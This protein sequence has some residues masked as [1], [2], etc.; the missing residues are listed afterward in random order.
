MSD[1]VGDQSTRTSERQ[2][3]ARFAV[4]SYER[5]YTEHWCLEKLMAALRERLTDPEIE[6]L[7]AEGA[8]WIEDRAV[9]YALTV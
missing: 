2:L 9:Q 1:G 6:R 4:L 5:E 7:A 3:D 8:A